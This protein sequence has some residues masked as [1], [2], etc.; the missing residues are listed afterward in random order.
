MRRPAVQTARAIRKPAP[1]TYHSLL[2]EWAVETRE[3]IIRS[4]AMNDD[5]AFIF[6]LMARAKELSP[7][8]EAE[9]H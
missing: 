2:R 1:R 7:R 8:I 6:V 3:Q 5:E 9:D 4:N